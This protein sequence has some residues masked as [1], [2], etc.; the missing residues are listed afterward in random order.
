MFRSKHKDNI[1]VK[2]EDMVSYLDETK[3]ASIGAYIA[4]YS[5]IHIP[6][7]EVDGLFENIK[8]TLVSNGLFLMSCQKG[9]FKGMEQEPYQQQ[10][11]ERLQTDE[12]LEFY[13]NYFVE[14]ELKIRIEKAG[15][16]V[17]LLNTFES[18]PGE[19]QVSKIWILA[20]K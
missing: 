1:E 15:L 3:S 14:E 13:I 6:D 12:K 11:D 18:Q 5:I 2:C 10:K 16:K 7:E 17:L 9:T 20:Q 8:R 4:K 19:M